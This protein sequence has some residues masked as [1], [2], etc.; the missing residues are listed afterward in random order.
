MN[1]SVITIP[2]FDLKC[3]NGKIIVHNA[4][5]ADPLKGEEQPCDRCNGRGF[6]VLRND[7]AIN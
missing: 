5:S 1:I 4:Y 7:V 6:I 3:H 2:C